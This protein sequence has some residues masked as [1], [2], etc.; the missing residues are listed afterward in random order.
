MLS[1]KLIHLIEKHEGEISNRIVRAIRNDSGLAH[2]ALLPEREMKERSREILQNLGYWLSHDNDKCLA[3][4]YEQLAKV[5]HQKSVPL[6]ESLLGL[7]LIKRKMFDF[8]D[9]QGLDQDCLTLYAEEQ[10]E[11]QVG[12]FFDVLMIHLANGYEAASQHTVQSA[13]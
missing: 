6:H 5:R 10:L 8:I 11:R 13:A 7:C 9:E 3:R 4:E 2:L 1:M 12:S